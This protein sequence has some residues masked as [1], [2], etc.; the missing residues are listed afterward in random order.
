MLRNRKRKIEYRLRDIDWEEQ[1]EP[2]FTASNI[3]FQVAQR[4]R[5]LSAGGIGVIHKLARETGL[6]EEIDGKL[7]LLKV[8]LPYHESDHVLNIAYNFMAGGTR[9]EHLE[10]LRNNEV[11][12]DA[13][14]AQRIPDPT[15]AGDFCRRF[16]PEDVELLMD[17]INETRLRVWKEQPEEF[18]REAIIEADGTFSQTSGECKEGMDI[19]HKGLWGYHPLVVSLANT[20]EPL[21]LV[22]RSGNRPS[23]EGA[24]E[25]FDQ[26]VYLCRRAGFKKITLRGDTDFSQTRHLDRWDD[27]KVRFV[28][29]ID[30]MPNLVEM[31]EN[32][33]KTAWRP[34]LRPAKY[35]VKTEPRRRPENVKDEIVR[36]RNFEKIKLISEHVA[37]FSY[38]PTHCKKT[39]RIIVLRKNLTVE[40][41]EL[42]LFDDV[43]YFFYITNDRRTSPANIVFEANDRCDQENLIAQLKSG[44]RA[45]HAPVDNLVSNWAYMVMASLAWSFKVWFALLLPEGGRWDK[46]YKA[47][48]KSV[49]RMEFRTFLNAFMQV[50]AQ[51]IRQGRRIIYRFLSWN[52][53]QPVFFRVADRLCGTLRC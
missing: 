36:K 32:L 13:L 44:V 15:T 53:W 52:Q 28:F 1:P 43:R 7:V 40:K 22:N 49:L 31:A 4:T 9:L 51:I 10:L 47:E 2:M 35:E 23:H 45:L 16:E 30:A 39:Y 11:Y 33:A 18:F 3:H 20:G 38:S 25:R 26:A 46:K 41:G 50:P 8:H 48:K 17:A 5:A 29:G 12:L 24:A 6:I 19:S 14:D 34:L 42:A 27:E 21:Y 37:E